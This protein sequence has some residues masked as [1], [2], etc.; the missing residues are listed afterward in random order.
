MLAL[1]HHSVAHFPPTKL[2]YYITIKSS[3]LFVAIVIIASSVLSPALD[4][5]DVIG[6]RM[7]PKQFQVARGLKCYL[8][9]SATYFFA[10]DMTWCRFLLIERS[11][12]GPLP[13]LP[14][15]SVL[16]PV[17]LPGFCLLS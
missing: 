4:G 16:S 15:F 1:F 7:L 5:C 13:S 17:A 6:L 12:Y 10:T 9:S 2:D 11:A 3:S 8:N 14:S